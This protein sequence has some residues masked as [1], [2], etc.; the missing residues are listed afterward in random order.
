MS[1]TAH[2]PARVNLLGEHTDYTGGL[3]LPLAIDRH[4]RVEASARSDGVIKIASTAEP[5]AVSAPA[6]QCPEPGPV[7]W[8]SYVL[9]VIAE[10]WDSLDLGGGVSLCIDGNIPL[11]AGLGSSASLSVASARALNDLFG[12]DLDALTLAQACQRAEQRFAHVQCGLM[13][14]AAASLSEPG[15]ALL[16]DCQRL[17]WQPVAMPE[18]AVV[19]AHSGIRHA[20]A[21]SAYNQRVEECRKALDALPHR[22]CLGEATPGDLEAASP[23]LG[24]TVQRRLEHVVRENQRVRQGVELLRAGDLKQFGSLMR[25]S[26]ASLRDLYQVSCP[27]LDALV[28]RLEPHAW[29][30]KMTGAGFGGAVV[31]LVD[32]DQVPAVRQALADVPQLLVCRPAG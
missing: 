20:L 13:D 18:V 8:T 14:Q 21:F 9:G 23:G 24:P 29:G 1:V 10:L 27:E 30:A 5:S 32:P 31:A 3:V 25:A 2:A 19:I 17:T 26:H 28:E 4:T 11:G 22:H 12:C 16:L 7:T 15:H 6:D